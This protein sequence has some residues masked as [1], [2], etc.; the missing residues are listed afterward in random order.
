MLGECFHAPPTHSYA[1]LVHIAYIVIKK[2]AKEKLKESTVTI[3]LV[4]YLLHL[5]RAG[6]LFRDLVL[7]GQQ[8]LKTLYS[9]QS[10]LRSPR[11]RE[12]FLAVVHELMQLR[13]D[14]G[15]LFADQ[16]AGAAVLSKQA[17]ALAPKSLNADSPPL[18]NA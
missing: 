17:R 9:D 7:H 10:L 4:Q 8:Y 6:A 1:C 3:L 2:M 18:P 15:L 13:F 16:D 12:E 14:F 5:D 11:Y